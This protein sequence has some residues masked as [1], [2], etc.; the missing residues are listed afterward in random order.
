M[1]LQVGD[2]APKQNSM[3]S[4]AVVVAP[5]PFQN[6]APEVQRTAEPE[7][8][9]CT[10]GTWIHFWTEVDGALRMMISPPKPARPAAARK[11]EPGSLGA[12]PTLERQPGPQRQ[13]AN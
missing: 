2:V 6:E 4:T 13:A 12:H 11:L 8:K 10:L 7:L 1:T 5:V 9:E 3:P